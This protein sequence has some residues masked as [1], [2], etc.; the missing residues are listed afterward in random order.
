MRRPADSGTRPHT[1]RSRTRG[2]SG[3][4]GSRA[5]RRSAPPPAG[6][7]AVRRHLQPLEQLDQLVRQAVRPR[8]LLE[9]LERLEY[10]RRRPRVEL[11]G[12]DTG[13]ALPRWGA[14]SSARVS[15]GAAAGCLR[16][17]AAARARPSPGRRA[18]ARTSAA[19]S[20]LRPSAAHLALEQVDGLRRARRAPGGADRRSDPRP[21][22][23]SR[24]AAHNA[25]SQQRSPKRRVP[26]RNPA[27]AG[28]QHPVARE[29]RLEQLTRALPASGR[30]RRS[31]GR[32]RPRAAP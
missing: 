11:L 4:R 6:G 12:G 10:S 15:G 28:G 8:Q 5:A 30:R 17:G 21:C 2:G 31:P 14:A 22:A 13:R 7:S 1:A 16:P 18:G 24:A 25:Q 9:L 20:R 26:E 27:S 23:E 3:G 29:R 19:P 32:R